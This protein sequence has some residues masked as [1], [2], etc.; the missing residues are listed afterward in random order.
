MEPSTGC[1][2][3]HLRVANFPPAL[4][5]ATDELFKSYAWRGDAAA[6]QAKAQRWV[7]AAAACYEIDAPEVL[8]RPAVSVGADGFGLYNALS[9]VIVLPKM[10]VISLFHFFRYAVQSHCA[11]CELLPAAFGGDRNG[12]DA[13][14]FSTSLFHSVRP[15]LFRTAVENPRLL[16][17][18]SATCAQ[19]IW[20]QPQSDP[21]EKKALPSLDREAGRWQAPFLERTKHSP[22]RSG[23]LVNE[24]RRQPDTATR[25]PND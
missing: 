23:P 16:A 5:E 25:T 1:G 11:S 22:A 7:D 21:P 14:A 10:S 4:L 2:P 8:I 18:L 24:D 6:K 15:E 19:P 17:S 9:N 20:S 3:H 12:E 13:A